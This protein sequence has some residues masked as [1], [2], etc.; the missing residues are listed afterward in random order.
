MARTGTV[1][2]HDELIKLGFKTSYTEITGV[3]YW[4][5]WRPFLADFTPLLF[6]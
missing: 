6:R 1:T 2:L 3:H 5:L 4:F